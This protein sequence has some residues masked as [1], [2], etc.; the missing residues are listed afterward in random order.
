MMAK[1]LMN[2]EEGIQNSLNKKQSSTVAVCAKEINK[3]AGFV[4]DSK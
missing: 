2:L 1:L 3:L 4:A